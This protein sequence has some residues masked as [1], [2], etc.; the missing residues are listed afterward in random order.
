M[1]FLRPIQWYHSHADPIWPDGILKFGF[2]PAL[3]ASFLTALVSLMSLPIRNEKGDPFTSIPFRYTYTRCFPLQSGLELKGQ[4]HERWFTSMLTKSWRLHLHTVQVHVHAVLPPAVRIT[5]KGTV[6][7]EKDIFTS[8][9][10]RYT[11]I[12]HAVLPP[13]VSIRIRG[14]VCERWPSSP[15]YHPVSCTLGAPP[16]CYNE[17]KLWK[18]KVK[19]F[20]IFLLST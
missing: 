10:F 3:N 20:K 8:I 11:Y 12:V 9:P 18:K 7:R 1:T 2:W 16:C 17:I 13:A 15:P 5:I 4:S 19:I 14:T 6:W